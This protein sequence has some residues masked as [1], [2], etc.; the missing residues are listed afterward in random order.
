ML[1]LVWATKQFRCY[2]HGR[3]FVARTD[4]AAWTYLRNFADQNSR[5]LRWSIKLSELDFG[6][7]HRAG[8]KLTHVDALSRHVGTTVQGGSLNWKARRNNKRFYDRKSKTRHFDVND[9]VYLFTP[10]LKA[11][12]TKKFQKFWSGPYKITR[13]ISELNY[14]IVGQDDIHII[15]HVNRLKKCYSRSLWKPT[16]NQKAQKKLPKQKTER[17]DSG[18]S[19]EEEINVGPFPLMTA[20][21]P[22]AVIESTT[23]QNPA[24]D[25]PDTD[26]RTLDTP[27]TSKEDLSYYPLDTP[28]SRRELQTTRTETPITRPRARNML[29]DMTAAQFAQI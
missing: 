15:V 7:Q 6:V 9:L 25:T 13:K 23:P 19:E 5:L 28:R 10:A 26:R 1:A 14:E 4:H 29:Q 11:G 2:L 12:Q 16:Q 22:T 17:Q 27:S 20:D 3:Q 24:L 8:T 21:N 18:E